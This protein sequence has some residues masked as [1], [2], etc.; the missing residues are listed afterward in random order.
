MRRRRAT[1][2]LQAIQKPIQRLSPEVDNTV[3]NVIEDE[4][5]ID[6]GLERVWEL[7]TEP[8]WWVPSDRE[9]TA[10]RSPGAVVVR[11]SAKYGRYAV[12]VVE[13]TPRTYAAFRWASLFP[14]GQLEP[15]KTTLVEFV[16]SEAA[17]AVRVNVRETGFAELDADEE[18]RQSGLASNTEGWRIELGELGQRAEAVV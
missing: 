15:G 6:A 13:L 3:E 14:G 10:E 9:V 12:E 18:A 1:L 2:D 5:T 8:G 17:D 4:I 16:L 7:V 11:E